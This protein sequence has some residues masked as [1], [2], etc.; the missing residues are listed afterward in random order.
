MTKRLGY[1]APLVFIAGFLLYS[2]TFFYPFQF[3]DGLLIVDNLR[4]RDLSNLWPPSG[5]RY[6]GVLTFAL[7]YHAGGLSTFG[8]H[9]VNTAVHCTTALLVFV[10]VV[11]TA[12]TPALRSSLSEKDAFV[13]AVAS[14]LLFLVHPVNTQAVTYIVQ[15]F[16]SLAAA[17][18]LL[19]IIFYAK[20]RTGRKD[21]P[22]KPLFF[23]LSFISSLFAIGSKE[24]AATLPLSILVYELCF[25]P[26]R[27][28]KSRKEAIYFILPLFLTFF[29]FI[30]VTLLGPDRLL[31]DPIGGIE[32][33][34]M[35]T[36]HISRWEYFVTQLRVLVTYIRLVFAP[37]GQNL[38]YDYPVYE[39]FF[40]LEVMFSAVA[41]V[42]LFALA[43]EL[44]RRSR[45]ET[46]GLYALISFGILWF[47]VTLS[48]ESSLIPIRDVIFEHRLY[49]PM[50]MASAAAVSSSFVLFRKYGL[51]RY[52]LLAF[53][54]V[55]VALAAATYKRNLVWKDP[56]TLW[57]DVT[58]KSMFKARGHHR[59]GLAYFE[60]GMLLEAA[61]E[62]EL[63]LRI[64]PLYLRSRVN[65]GNIY[66]TIGRYGE[67]E[68]EFKR[69]LEV[70]PRQAEAL[71]NLGIVYLKTGRSD[72]AAAEFK[73][74]A[75]ADPRFL[76][77][78]FNLG[79]AYGN[80]GRWD[81]AERELRKALEID[82]SDKDVLRAI[83][84]LSSMRP[85]PAPITP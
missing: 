65:L 67:A 85:A 20:A 6:I 16:A 82:P 22:G 30:P 47:F 17:F 73:K 35:E 12:K 83:S 49:L 81:E 60:K 21:S 48:V 4:I 15:R 23:V 63:A 40:N 53:L 42:T 70:K 62:Y 79:I 59:L 46:R 71:N 80:M 72:E 52:L 51:E 5:K 26:S 32:G 7:N 56:V 9:L 29:V 78:H 69:V 43:L 8:Y 36:T 41:L 50:T 84:S 18:Y 64:D 77:A 66:A 11:L 24:T 28:M 57:T 75:E 38:D 45:S 25:F 14:S 19:A 61:S 76:D 1:I 33:L 44:L 54:S 2:N 68:R 10:L 27:D 34:T 31:S 13:I 3:D 55:A 37:V 58:Q 74:A 39:S